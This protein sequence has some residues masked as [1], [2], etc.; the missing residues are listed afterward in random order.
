M[1][2]AITAVMAK[3]PKILAITDNEVVCSEYEHGFCEVLFMIK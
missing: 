3:A 1:I 2:N